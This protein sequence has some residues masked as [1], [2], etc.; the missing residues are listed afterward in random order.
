M[1]HLD[2]MNLNSKALRAVLLMA[3]FV[4]VSG[5]GVYSQSMGDVIERARTVKLLAADRIAVRDTFFDFTI[6]GSY[7]NRDEFTFGDIEISVYYS[8]G[9]CDDDEDE[10]FQAEKGKA[11]RIEI[12]SSVE[13]TIGQLGFELSK[14][15]KEQMY[16]FSDSSFIYHDK[17]LGLAV[18][19]LADEVEEVILFPS[20]TSEAKPCGF[21]KAREFVTLESWFGSTKL[22]DRT[23]TDFCRNGPANVT[24]LELERDQITALTPKQIKI[25][26]VAQDPENDP[27][28]YDYVVSAGRI[29]GTGAK[30]VW[31]LTGVPPG[32]YKITAAVDDGCGFCG[33]PVTKTVT[34][35]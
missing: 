35:K 27:L 7:D 12:A 31:D 22:E 25:T 11:I 23:G 2:S 13:R 32:T 33:Q 17:K 34:I 15:T 6:D 18:Q 21:E 29:I 8:T 26:T 19:I 14:F 16:Q 24:A 10:I 5:V 30:V 4:A 28:I 3:V 1:F 20:T 9:E